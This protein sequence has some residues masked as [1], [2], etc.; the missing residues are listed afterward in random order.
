MNFSLDYL[1]ELYDK[2]D[3]LCVDNKYAAIDR[4]TSK[5]YFDE[6]LI[7][8]VKFAHTWFKANVYKIKNIEDEEYYDEKDNIAFNDK[9]SLVY[10]ILMTYSRFSL[11]AFNKLYSPEELTEIIKTRS[12]YKYTKEII[13]GIFQDEYYV[14]TLKDWAKRSAVDKIKVRQLKNKSE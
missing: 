9:V 8:G 13:D 4:K 14:E 10:S 6:D 7:K 12:Q 1:K 2:Y 3:I 5:A 11:I